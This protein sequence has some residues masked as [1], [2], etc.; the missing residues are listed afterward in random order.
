MDTTLTKRAKDKIHM[1]A[2]NANVINSEL[3]NK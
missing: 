2:V 1:F 3:S